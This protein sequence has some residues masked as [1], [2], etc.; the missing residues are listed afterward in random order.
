MVVFFDVMC[1]TK[2][3]FVKL[4]PWKIANKANVHHVSVF[5]GFLVSQLRKSVNNNTEQD[6]EHDNI[7][8]YEEGEVVEKLNKILL[9]LIVKVYRFSYITNAASIP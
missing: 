1:E 8:D 6:I 4:Q 9:P 3:I 5:N 7:D 2:A